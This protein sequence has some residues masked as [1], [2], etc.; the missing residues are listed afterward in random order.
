MRGQQLPTLGHTLHLCAHP[1][2]QLRPLRHLVAQP[3]HEPSH[4]FVA[5][6][7][8]RERLVPHLPLIEPHPLL[9]LRLQQEVE[10]VGSVAEG[11]GVAA[12]ALVDDGVD[13]A[14]DLAAAASD[15][16][17]VEDGKGGE[18]G[19]VREVEEVAQ[20]QRVEQ[21]VEGVVQ[22]VGAVGQGGQGSAER[23]R[24]EHREGQR[25]HLGLQVH[26]TP[27]LYPYPL[28][29]LPD[30]RGCEVDDERHHRLQHPAMEPA[31]HHPPVPAHDTSSAGRGRG[32]DGSAT[33]PER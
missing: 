23:A 27:P 25:R 16:G 17:Q 10:E 15:V 32:V 11:G 13:E 19:D 26:P 6:K 7:N 5:C 4:R 29:Q 21:R 28:T 12:A 24:D 9:I 1:P 22:R 18:E 8:E 2:H 3:T 31:H 20:V 30:V 33:H 14:F